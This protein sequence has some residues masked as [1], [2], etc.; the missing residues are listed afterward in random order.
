MVPT[1]IQLPER[2]LFRKTDAPDSCLEVTESF[3]SGN[4]S[5]VPQVEQREK[6]TVPRRR[7]GQTGDACTAKGAECDHPL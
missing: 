5:G 6:Q 3:L 7:H 2:T 1:M 4:P